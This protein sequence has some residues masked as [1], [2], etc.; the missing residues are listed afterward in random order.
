MQPIE[1]RFW[2]KVDKRGPDDCWPWTG[3]LERNGYARVKR[4]GKQI[5]VHRIAF[6]L[7]NGAIEP[8]NVVDHACHN[9]ADCPGG[10]DCKHRACCNPG[11]LESVTQRENVLR[12]KA[13]QKW[14]SATHCAKGHAW[15]TENTYHRPNKPTHKQCIRCMR[16]STRISRAKKRADSKWQAKHL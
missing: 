2:A 12:G 6:E 15:T 4:S 10:Y 8:G 9:D 14:A 3:R 13:G 5:L 11:H 7:S 1:T 16:E